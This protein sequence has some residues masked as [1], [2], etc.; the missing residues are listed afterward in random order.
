MIRIFP[1]AMLFFVVAAIHGCGYRQISGRSEFSSIRIMPVE[2]RTRE[3]DIPDM[4][5][6]AV[7][8][9]LLIDRRV[10]VASS[11]SDAQLESI[12]TAYR[13]NPTAEA[14]DRATQYE[15]VLAADFLVKDSGGK[16]LSRIKGLEP[17]VREVFSVGADAAAAKIGEEAARGKAVRALAR[18]LRFRMLPK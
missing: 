13:L 11:N 9:E 4:L 14:G 17:P 8:E 18:E 1:A 7:A 12:V 15:I 3:P 6:Q 16:I 2:N 10:T 5:R